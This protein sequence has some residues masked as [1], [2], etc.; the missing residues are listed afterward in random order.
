MELDK[1]VVSIPAVMESIAMMRGMADSL[2][3]AAYSLAIKVSL[4]SVRLATALERCL[5]QMSMFS[6]IILMNFL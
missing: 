3:Q 1:P 6:F 2:P 4:S 5:S